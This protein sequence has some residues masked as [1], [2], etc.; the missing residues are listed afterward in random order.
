MIID[1]DEKFLLMLVYLD[2]NDYLDEYEFM[3][4]YTHGHHCP[5]PLELRRSFVYSLSPS[6][7]DFWDSIEK[8]FKELLHKV[9]EDFYAP[10]YEKPISFLDRIKAMFK[11]GGIVE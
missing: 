4:R 3:T 10:I 6:G 8:G 9:V 5:W 1:E 7:L 11:K 2:F